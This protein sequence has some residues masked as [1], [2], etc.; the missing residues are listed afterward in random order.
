MNPASHGPG[1]ADDRMLRTLGY[2]PEL[3]RRMSA[4]SNFAISLSIICILAGGITSFHVGLGSVG[5]AGIG[6]GWPVGCL[7][8][9]AVAASMAHIASAFPTAG[10]LYHWGCILGGRGLGWT[11][12]WFNLAGLVTVLATV[13]AGTYDF[14]LATMGWSP[15]AGRESVV[16]LAVVTAMVLSQGWL[17]HHGM[18]W[19]TRLTDLSGWLILVL[20]AALVGGLAW[21]SPSLDPGRLWRFENFSGVAVGGAGFPRTENLAWL[22]ALGL[23]LPAYTITGFDASAHTAEET[24]EASQNVPRGILRSVL[25]SG[26]AGW[27]MVGTLLLALPSI[28][29]GVGKGAEVV[30]WVISQRLPGWAAK[31]LLGGIVLVQYL[32]GLAALTSASRMVFAFARD[33]GLPGSAWLRR[34]DASTGCPAVAVWVAALLGAAFSAVVP[35]TTIAVVCTVF[36][37]L[38]YVLPIAAGW[39]A[40]G[41]RWT[42]PGTWSLGRAFKPLAAVSVLGCAGLLVV[43]V[44][45]PNQLAVPIVLGVSA[46]MAVVWLGWERRRFKGPPVAGM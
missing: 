2:E 28:R 44:Q 31:G 9:L 15:P 39:R 43:G 45:P 3:R 25:V 7:F 8:S 19:V 26:L 30:P 10:G 37:Y 34:V 36:L 4:F 18:R 6:V 41:G 27:A 46:L 40:W 5:G 12:A 29:E 13:N 11:T 23:M 38:S 14:A 17:N 33:G 24:V 1:N 42:R 22:F 16:K 32:C 35:Y 21:A 20:T